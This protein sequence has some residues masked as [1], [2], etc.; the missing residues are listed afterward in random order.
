M[1]LFLSKEQKY[2]MYCYHTLC[3]Q[4]L[5]LKPISVS[6]NT[7]SLVLFKKK[8]DKIQCKF[9]LSAINS[10]LFPLSSNLCFTLSSSS[11]LPHSCKVAQ[12]SIR[13]RCALLVISC[14]FSFNLF[15]FFRIQTGGQICPILK[16]HSLNFST[17]KRYFPISFHFTLKET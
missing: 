2:T 14:F 10:N 9:P 4:Q 13:P 16:Q 12:L 5:Y 17:S 1:Q 11:F 7:E 8:I 6:Y 3:L 15:L